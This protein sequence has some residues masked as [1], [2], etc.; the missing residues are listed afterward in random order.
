MV[1]ITKYPQSCFLLEKD[2]SRILIDPGNFVAEK[3]SL[4]DFLPL[5]AILLTHLHADHA[6]P[7][8]LEQANDRGVRV[9][10]NQATIDFL[11]ELNFELISDRETV[12]I[13]DFSVKAH[14]LPHVLMVD[15][16]PGPQNTGYVV[17]DVFFHPGD[18]V[19]ISG[20]SID[21]LAVPIAGPDLS[22]HDA[23]SLITS[24]GT[25]L[26]IPMHYNYF[27]NDPEFFKKIINNFLPELE[28]V[29]LQNGDSREISNS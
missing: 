3:Y 8:I 21:C 12:V 18:G 17:D 16:K 13:S 28:V 27:P 19:E 10:A 7:N 20:L 2:N 29:V 6:D 25:K 4:S 5:D 11:S 1:K 14:E 9:I 24:V 22:P 26:A 23:Y 15:G